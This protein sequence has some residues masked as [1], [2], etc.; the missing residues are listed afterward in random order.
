MAS[1]TDGNRDLKARWEPAIPVRVALATIKTSA[2]V[3]ES[4]VDTE[5]KVADLIRQ[6]V[7]RLERR[8]NRRIDWVAVGPL[9]LGDSWRRSGDGQMLV[10]FVAEATND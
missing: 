5:V 7:L 9:M 1:S 2:I 10:L 3:H 6:L 4:L 8:A